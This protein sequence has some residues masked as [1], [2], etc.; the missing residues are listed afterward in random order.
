[1]TTYTYTGFTAQFNDDDTVENVST[2]TVS[3]VVDDSVTGFDYQITQTEADSLNE[4]QIDTPIINVRLNEPGQP[5][6]EFTSDDLDTLDVQVGQVNWGSNQVSYLL[7]FS[8]PT[9]PT[10]SQTFVLQIGGPTLP[11]IT[12]Q[13]QLENF[14]GVQANSIGGTFS[15]PFGPN[16]TI[17]FSS[18]P[19]RSTTNDDLIQGGT[20]D[21]TLDGGVGNDTINTGGGDDYEQVF[22]GPGNDVI[23]LQPTL[24]TGPRPSFV[25]LLYQ[26]LTGPL[27][28]NFDL[29]ANSG[30]VTGGGG[31]TD[32]ING[33]ATQAS[34]ITGWGLGFVATGGNDVFNITG[35]NES[36]LQIYGGGGNDTFN[37]DLNAGGTVRW[38]ANWDGNNG[39][40]EGVIADFGAGTVTQDGFGGSD[41]VTVTRTDP[42]SGRLS[43]QTDNFDDNVTGTDGRDG[44]ILGGG[45]DT[46][47]GAGG[48]DRVRYDRGGVDNVVV[49]L[50]A[51]TAT[52]NWG[53]T[54]FNHTLISIEDVRGSRS[55]TS[56]DDITGS[57]ADNFLDGREGDDLLNALG[58]DDYIEGGPGNDTI[59]T[60]LG[61]DNLRGEAGDDTYV[62]DGSNPM[63]TSY[64]ADYEGTNTLRVVNFEGTDGNEFYVDGNDLVRVSQQGHHTRI[65]GGT[66]SVQLIEWTNVGETGL[67]NTLDLI[68]DV[69]DATRSNFTFAG[70]QNDET[71]NAPTLSDT[72]WAE[73]YLNDGNDSYFGTADYLI[74][75][76]L[77]NGN[78]TGTGGSGRDW[79]RGQAGDDS[80]IGGDGQDTLFGED[81]N[82]TLLGGNDDDH[83]W[84]SGMGADVLDGGDGSD[85]AN[86][87]DATGRV[88]VDFQS[89]V[90]GAGFVRFFDEGAA[91]GDTFANIENAI[92]GDF[93]DNLRGDGASNMLEGGGVSDR[94]YGRA[95]DDILDGGT[96]A[97]AMYGN[98]GADTMTGGDDAGRR[99]RYIYFQANETGVGSGNRDVITDFVSGEDRIELSR[100][101]ADITQGFKQRFDFVGDA[102][103]TG[104]AGEL[105]Y[106]QTGGITLVQADRD[107]DGIADMEIELTG[108]ID[109]VA[110][111][112]LI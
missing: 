27:T 20:G 48:L 43:I 41:T 54:P 99:D 73:V 37:I 44:F 55:T 66:Q 71:F 75:A 1:M 53:G 82:D 81:G 86:Y 107:G 96:G 38:R 47:D 85:T 46:A 101:D 49:D 98:L 23:N 42:N 59:R 32:T 10:T 17:S 34:D 79:I 12:N 110:G 84:A 6:R 80:L 58:G 61:N 94:L 63:T 77:G 89:D 25:E 16:Q 90:S 51:G 111:D 68:T 28:V 14:L 102:A 15:G 67:I 31:G 65:E 56:G 22:G 105:R 103:F 40:T 88:L 69:N 57:S 104:T 33:L 18:I 45:N 7:T 112:F 36:Y 64:I 83:L 4:V 60:G 19:N 21:D 93:A 11:Q 5:L 100:I 30:T 76:S 78:D 97:D 26:N 39:P 74:F 29:G 52:G 3:I 92:G 87:S 95:G 91:T 62:V 109:L 50:E 24:G 13:S 2:A 72:G 9:G 70:S 108:T 35:A 106:E 8:V